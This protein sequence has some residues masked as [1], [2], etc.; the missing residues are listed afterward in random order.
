MPL[1]RRRG[2]LLA[3]GGLLLLLAPAALAE[4]T[5]VIVMDNGNRLVAEIKKLENGLLEIS[6]TDINGRVKVEWNHVVRVTCNR[7]LIIEDGYGARLFGQLIDSGV[8]DILRVQTPYGLVDVA[9]D[10]VVFMEPIQSTFLGRLSGDLST[11]ISYTKSTEILQ[12]NF[13]GSLRHRTR[14]AVTEISLN[15]IITAKSEGNKTNTDLPVTYQRFFAN[16]WFY[17]GDAGLNRNDEL[18]IDLRTGIAAGA[19]R[20]LVYSNSAIVQASLLLNANREF[21]SDG[22]ETNNLE[23]VLDTSLL[24]F[25]YDTPKLDASLTVDLFMNLTTWG[26]YRVNVDGRLSIELLGDFYWDISQ[27]YYRFDTDPST[28]A[29]SGTDWGVISG[30]RYTFD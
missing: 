4:K 10:D 30:L 21:T 2:F 27:V 18:G 23:L 29:T 16:R 1:G 19:G 13:G 12:F 8:D 5:D 28:T 25:R 15:T 11:G 7:A 22:D 17:R 6:M 26:R 14:K 9:R 20:R 3:L 24:A